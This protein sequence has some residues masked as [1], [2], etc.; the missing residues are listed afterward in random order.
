MDPADL[1]LT[2]PYRDVAGYIVI[3]VTFGDDRRTSPMILDT[4]APTIIT[5]ELAEVF[6]GDPAGT[7]ATTSADGQVATS[8]VVPLSTISIGGVAFRD[9]GAVVGAIEPGNPFYCIT[10]AGFIGTSLLQTAVW[11]IDPVAREVTIAA[12]VAGLDH[13]DGAERIDF[14]RASEV[15]TLDDSE[16]EKLQQ[17]GAQLEVV[18]ECA[19]RLADAGFSCPDAAWC[20]AHSRAAAYP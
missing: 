1:P 5:E 6:A 17:A 9:V 4:G 12:S 8:T 15:R 20:A 18:P 13:I 2:L 3:D 10:D 7:I 19:G 14:R 11:Q 16:L